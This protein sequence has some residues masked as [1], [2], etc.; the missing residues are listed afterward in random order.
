MRLRRIQSSIPQ[1]SVSDFSKK[2]RKKFWDT[3]QSFHFELN[4]Q[5]KNE[6]K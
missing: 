6:Q 3:Y 5:R 2:N 1:R 4:I